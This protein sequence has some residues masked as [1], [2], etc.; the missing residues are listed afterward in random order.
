M[1]NVVVEDCGDPPQERVLSTQCQPEASRK[2]AEAVAVRHPFG[3]HH[4]FPGLL[5]ETIEWP[6]NSYTIDLSP[7]ELT[8]CISAG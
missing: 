3:A 1:K 7:A 5:Q 8:M 6:G 4:W 2:V